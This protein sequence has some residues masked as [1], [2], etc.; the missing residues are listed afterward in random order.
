MPC[1][2]AFTRRIMKS[3]DCTCGTD[4]RSDLGFP[5]DL[6]P[7]LRRGEPGDQPVLWR[8]RQW[9]RRRL[10]EL[11]DGEP[12]GKELLRQLWVAARRVVASGSRG[13]AR[14]GLAARA[15]G[16]RATA[17][18]GAL[19]RPRRVHHALRVTRLGGGT[20]PALTLLRGLPPPGRTLRRARS[21]SSSATRS[22]P[23]GA[24]PS[25][26]RT[27]RSGLSARRSTSSRRSA[28]SAPRSARRPAGAR[29]GAHRRGGRHA[30]RRS[31]RAWSPATSSTPP[32]ASSPPPS[33]G[34][35][36]S[37][38]RRSARRKRRS[39]T[40][41]RASTSSRARPSRCRSGARSA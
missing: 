12:A 5:C 24:R 40:R 14:H 31:R 16:R 13:R 1:V 8:L 18:L 27:T 2:G 11:R 15:C 3:P 19:R 29:R 21:R 9:P 37:A 7:E 17:R 6:M 36:S 41:T 38:S 4:C 26:R 25:R 28:S 22:W 32:R 10:R 20:R 23:C 33:P 35:S 39:R 30:R 34:R